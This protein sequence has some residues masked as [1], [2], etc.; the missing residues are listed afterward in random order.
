MNL[1]L[2][3]GLFSLSNKINKLEGI[4]ERYP[5]TDYNINQLERINNYFEIKKIINTLENPNINQHQKILL[6]QQNHFLFDDNFT[7]N[8]TKAGL[9]DDYN[10]SID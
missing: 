7:P 3:F 1:K 8:I 6:I 10:F 5:S 2:L 4:D 9:L